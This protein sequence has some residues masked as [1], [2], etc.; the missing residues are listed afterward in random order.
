MPPRP[1]AAARRA[2][3]AASRRPS[4]TARKQAPSALTRPRPSPGRIATGIGLIAGVAALAAGGIAAGM[5]LEHRL[6]SKRLKAQPSDDEQFFSLRS[7]G[8]LVTTPDG[9][10]LHIEVD[11]RAAGVDDP[12]DLT[13][14]F[15]HGYALSLDCWHF[16]RKHYRGHLRQVFYDQRSHGR[17][18]R[19]DP[20]LCR[21]P[22]LA[23]DLAQ[24]LDEVAGRGP[25]ILV[26]HSMGGMTIMHL[27]QEH[28]EWFTSRVLG[29]ALFST[30]AGEMA[31]YSPIRGIPG[32]A[33]S[34]VAPPLLATLNRIPELVERGRRAGSDI[35]YVVT[36]RMSFGSDVPVSYVQF[37]SDMLGDTPLEVVA[38]Y[39][40]A[41]S[42]L[43]EFEAFAT[44][45][46]V[47]TAVVGGE[48]DVITPVNH[49]DRIIELLPGADVR[50]L[51]N[52]G[53]MGI[54]EHHDIFNEVLDGL[55]ERV[56]RNLEH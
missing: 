50:R 4:V 5:E 43:D 27:A 17:S 11:E 25:L 36:R 53:H 44:L 14:V 45:S 34:R 56:R 16:Q 10:I 1:R 49:T 40:P 22:Q 46:T 31:D 51:P 28:P 2:P 33:F 13:V 47:E 30:A 12:D 52:C 35:G 41:F 24:V 6:I 42:E 9:V 15:V 39:Y 23:E 38:D 19:S 37:M 8:P 26:G 18:G 32:R 3:A 21:V 54:I 29:V 20:A 48:D 55:I 7:D